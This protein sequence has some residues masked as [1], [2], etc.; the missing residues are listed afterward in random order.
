[1]ITSIFSKSKPINFL[2][3][4]VITV[5]AFVIVKLRY[6]QELDTTWVIIK[7]IAIFL[8]CYLSVLL[9]NFI[10]NK[11]NLTQKNNLEILLFSLFFVIMPESL[12]DSYCI[13]A[14]LLILMALRRL[15]SLH[16]QKEVKQKLFDASLWIALASIFYF[17]SI[18]FFILIL[19]ALVL[20]TDNNIK[21]WIIPFISLI[22]VFVISVSVSV[23]LYEDYV[24]LFK[25]KPQVSFDFIA[26]N[27]KPFL[28][29][30]TLFFSFGLWSAFYY[31]RSFKD[32]MKRIRPSY[33]LIFAALFIAFIIITITPNKNGSEFIFF[34][35]PLAIIITNYIESIKE[36][37][38]KELF[39]AVLVIAP[40]IILML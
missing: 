34:F 39:L 18:L 7:Q 22:T 26:Y 23:I 32:K 24:M 5:L 1:M 16:S 38:F 29:A 28:V 12:R 17:W 9:L 3:V 11:N 8:M 14:N 15:L 33:K 30:I 10:A 6:L 20:Y 13:V 2:I 19:I 27:S 36:K 35:A 37:W 21:H 40:L 31:L 4:F 25:S